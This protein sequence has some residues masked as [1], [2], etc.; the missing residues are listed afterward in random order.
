M[1][2]RILQPVNNLL[3]LFSIMI[4]L[5]ILFSLIIVYISRVAHIPNMLDLSIPNPYSKYIALLSSIFTFLIP[6]FFVEKWTNK[7]WLSMSD[8]SQ[9]INFRVLGLILL[10]IVSVGITINILNIPLEWFSDN[11]RNYSVRIEQEY[12]LSIIN[13]FQF[14]T[15]YDLIWGIFIIGIVAAIAEEYF[16]RYYIQQQLI[17]LTNRPWVGIIIA[18]FVFSAFHFSIIG[19]IPRFIL[20]GALGSVFYLTRNIWYSIFFHF[21]NN[22]AIVISLYLVKGGQKEKLA[23]LNDNNFDFLTKNWWLCFFSM[24]FSIYLLK[25]IAYKSNFSKTNIIRD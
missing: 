10:L 21:I 23:F 22:S 1:E 12:N 11:I 9:K 19:C 15:I 6:C 18:S 2:K 13:T 5:N 24:A 25:K 14:N 4:I 8:I 17:Q 20:G 16:F 3:I 7:Q